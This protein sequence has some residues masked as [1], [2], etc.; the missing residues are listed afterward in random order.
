MK[1]HNNN[2][3][4]INKELAEIDRVWYQKYWICKAYIQ[5]WY[6]KF[7]T[8]YN[9]SPKSTNKKIKLCN[10]KRRQLSIQSKEKVQ[11]ILIKSVAEAEKLCVEIL[12]K[13]QFLQFFK[14][15]SNK[16][17]IFLILEYSK[18]SKSFLETQKNL[19]NNVSNKGVIANRS[20]YLTLIKKYN[21]KRL[22]QKPFQTFKKKISAHSNQTQ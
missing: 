14:N 4:L 12:L 2:N 20:I 21:I 17:L 11:N 16:Y 8:V 5:S 3:Y 22:V 9:S 19:I 7:S 6:S 18:Y 15:P 1:P 13:I 10:E